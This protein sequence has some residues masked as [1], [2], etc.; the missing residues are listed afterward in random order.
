MCH[1]VGSAHPPKKH[2]LPSPDACCCSQRLSAP[3]IQAKKNYSGENFGI[4]R[5]HLRS[6]TQRRCVC[7]SFIYSTCDVITQPASLLSLSLSCVK[8]WKR[9]WLTPAA[10]TEKVRTVGFLKSFLHLN[11]VRCCCRGDFSDWQVPIKEMHCT[12]LQ[13][14]RF[15]RSRTFTVAA[16]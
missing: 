1:H 6:A 4:N 11:E 9:E 7:F 15:D 8:Q 16:F 5:E 14:G 12:H 10:V 3:V 13:K 2:T